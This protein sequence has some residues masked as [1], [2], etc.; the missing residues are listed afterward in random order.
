[1]NRRICKGKKILING[2]P[3][4]NSAKQAYEIDSKM[5]KLYA[6]SYPVIPENS[7]LVL[8]DNSSGSFD[9]SH[10]G[11]IDRKQIVGRVILQSKSL[12]PSQP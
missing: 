2:K 5:L 11:F 7:Y 9:A 6:D 4:Q 12:H 8:G 1:M 10:F 3:L